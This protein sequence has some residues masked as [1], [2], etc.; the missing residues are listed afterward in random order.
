MPKDATPDE[1]VI[2]NSNFA[3]DNHE[4]IAHILEEEWNASSTFAG[5]EDRCNAHPSTIRAVYNRYMGVPGDERTI[6]EIKDEYDNVKT[7][8]SL[9][10]AGEIDLEQ[11]GLT[12][13][14]MRFFQE[15]FRKGKVIGETE[16]WDRALDQAEVRGPENVPRMGDAKERVPELPD[17]NEA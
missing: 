9:R 1:L 6:D 5:L 7:Y 3:N 13:R 2:V 10:A 12:E 14:E 15:G 16:G 17:E 8:L 11:E 4:K